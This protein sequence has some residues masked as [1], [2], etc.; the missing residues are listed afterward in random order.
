MSW[1]SGVS[2]ECKCILGRWQMLALG[3]NLTG[4]Y[5][6]ANENASR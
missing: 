5:L 2:E 3:K 1:P 4:K 6:Q